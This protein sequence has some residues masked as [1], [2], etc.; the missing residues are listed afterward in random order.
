MKNNK[1]NKVSVTQV[2]K[3]LKNYSKVK[4][5]QAIGILEYLFEEKVWNTAA[6]QNHTT[7]WY[8]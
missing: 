7:L 3:L 2:N 1:K 6:I 4:E 5:K 8:L